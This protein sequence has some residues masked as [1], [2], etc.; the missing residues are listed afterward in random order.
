MITEPRCSDQR[1]EKGTRSTRSEKIDEFLLP[2]ALTG[3]VSVQ[4]HRVFL[5]ERVH[6][7]IVLYA[8]R[9]ELERGDEMQ[10]V[11]REGR[12]MQSTDKSTRVNAHRVRGGD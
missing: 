5:R 11:K 8:R 3:V 2:S 4:V 12:E 9:D 7:C 1:D 10:I 6:V